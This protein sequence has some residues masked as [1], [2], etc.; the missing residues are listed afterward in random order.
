MPQSWRNLYFWRLACIL[1]YES[2]GEDKTDIVVQT[3]NK[4]ITD[5]VLSEIE[6]YATLGGKAAEI[7]LKHSFSSL[8]RAYQD[9]RGW[10]ELKESKVRDEFGMNQNKT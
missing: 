9:I 3:R 5:T 6:S 8:T 4:L 2:T 1:V 10:L 7:V